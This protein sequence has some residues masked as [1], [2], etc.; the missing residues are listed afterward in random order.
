M[1]YPL[2]DSVFENKQSQDIKD[3]DVK[4]GVLIKEKDL[5]KDNLYTNEEEKSAAEDVDFVV[6]LQEKSI[7]WNVKNYN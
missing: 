4:R 1:H 2:E 3:A 6:Q 7:S 5:V